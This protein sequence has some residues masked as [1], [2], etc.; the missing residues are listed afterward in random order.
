M[1]ID[2]TAQEVLENARNHGFENNWDDY[3]KLCLIHSEISEAMEEIRHGHEPTELYFTKDKDGKD[4]PEGFGI[5]LADAVIRIMHSC[6]H[7]NISLAENIK[8]KMAYNEG[9]PYMHNLKA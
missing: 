8:I 6:A 2:K 5:E 4:K 1:D 7:Y 9:R 3:K